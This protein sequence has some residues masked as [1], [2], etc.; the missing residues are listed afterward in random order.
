MSL[1]M[2]KETLSEERFVWF[3]RLTLG[4]CTR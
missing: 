3:R 2:K 4:T 1:L